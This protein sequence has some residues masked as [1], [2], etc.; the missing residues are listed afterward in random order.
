MK[1]EHGLQ[2]KIDNMSYELDCGLEFRLLSSHKI[3][4]Q[5]QTLNDQKM[6]KFSFVRNYPCKKGR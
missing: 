4:F 1:N 2:L 6:F 5:A 3:E